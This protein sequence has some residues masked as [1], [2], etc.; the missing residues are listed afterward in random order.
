ML[1]WGLERVIAV[2]FE[3][4]MK[5]HG[6][7]TVA[8]VYTYHLQVVPGCEGQRRVSK[9]YSEICEGHYLGNIN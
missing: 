1:K 9:F 7:H 8:D 4:C 6:A 2:V 3:N 5:G